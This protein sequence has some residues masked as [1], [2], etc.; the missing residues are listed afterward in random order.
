MHAVMSRYRQNIFTRFS[1]EHVWALTALVAVFAFVNTHPV[2]PHDFWWHAQVGREILNTGRI[3]TVDAYS[4][5]VLGRAYPS[6]H[7]FWLMET[8]LYGLYAMGGAALLVFVHG[9]I[10]TSA[11]GALLWLSYRISHSWRVAALSMLFAAALG[12]NDWNVR[13]QALAFPL[14]AL[15]LA[16]VYHYRRERASGKGARV[17]FGGLAV[18]GV[19]M[20]VW[21]NSH[22]SF[23][24]GLVCLGIWVME[25]SWEVIKTRLRAGRWRDISLLYQPGA[26]LLVALLACLVNPRGPGILAYLGS[27]GGNPVI[28]T[29]VVEWAPPTFDTLHGE[30]FLIGL[31]LS[32]SVLALSARRPSL[33]QM[34][35][36]VG[37]GALGLKTG[38]GAVWFGIVMAPVLADHLPSLFEE[39]QSLLGRTLTSEQEDQHTLLNYS[40]GGLVLLGALISL[41]WFKDMLHL[42][43]EKGGLLSS[44]T[45]VAAT[46]FL[47]REHPPGPLFHEMSF[48]SYLI[49]AAQP[50]YPVFIDPRIELYPPEIWRDYIAISAGQADWDTRLDA[51]AINTL[52]ISPQTQAPLYAAAQASD[53][54]RLIYQ[55]PSAAIFARQTEE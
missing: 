4:F 34:L 6:Y 17:H 28:Q 16:L 8:V 7:S 41:P 15:L 19:A 43:G 18:I 50:G 11:Y 39:A 10:I 26:A 12:L 55:D 49:W 22:G 9:L 45:P 36:F 44:E 32:A 23:A 14:A 54:W 46:E 47:L 1:V 3:P 21:V 25:A 53:R 2:R 30:L 37:F 5:T 52:M 42:P 27:I 24:I 29:M 38:R 31:L 48:G 40:L 20:A 33:F 35:T 13:P 51:Y